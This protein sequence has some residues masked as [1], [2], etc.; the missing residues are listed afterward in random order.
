[1]YNN[2]YNM[3]TTPQYQN[4]FAQAPRQSET[5]VKKVNGPEG[6]K[7]LEMPANSDDIFLDMNEAIFY[8]VQTD[9]VGY[10]TITP[11]DFTIHKEVSVKDQYKS[12]EERIK[13]LEEAVAHNVKSNY[14][15]NDQRSK[16]GDKHNDAGVRS[17]A[18]G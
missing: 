17:N 5:H 15:P 9:G 12:L 2:P 1:M 10:K 13:K 7:N 11:Y 18:Q 8:F 3:Q 6:I 14:R 4:M 16:S